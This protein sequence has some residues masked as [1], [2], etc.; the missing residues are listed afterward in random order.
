[1]DAAFYITT[2][3]DTVPQGDKPEA[4]SYAI[5]DLAIAH[6]LLPR[7]YR[8]MAN[9]PIE[10]W[11]LFEGTE[12]QTDWASGPILVDLRNC[13]TF[14]QQLAVDLESRPLGIMIQTS[15]D[16]TNLRDRCQQWLFG[17]GRARLLRFYEPRMLGPLLCVMGQVQLR[18]FMPPDEQ[19]SWHDGLKWRT[20]TTMATDSAA[21]KDYSLISVSEEQLRQISPYR[22]AAQAE[23]FANYYGSSLTSCKDPIVWV[24]NCLLEAHGSGVNTVSDQERWL[25]LAIRHGDAFPRDKPYQEVL[26]QEQWSA[27]ERLTAMESIRKQDYVPAA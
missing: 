4:T 21:T 11:S 8:A 18:Q 10:W 17:A 16:A 7:L 12:W 2:L 26:L 14:T 19:W 9:E 25:R 22:M 20:R 1:M 3:E 24:L 6:D 13:G 27:S 23:S 5:V 15:L